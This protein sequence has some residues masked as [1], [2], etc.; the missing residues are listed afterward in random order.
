MMIMVIIF[1][2][3]HLLMML[4][5]LVLFSSITFGRP[6]TAQTKTLSQ[7]LNLLGIIFTGG[8]IN[9][10]TQN[11]VYSAVI[12]MKWLQEFIWFI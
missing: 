5:H 11:N 8:I 2:V 1:L 4:C 7:S 10:N 9:A 6:L 3:W 12:I